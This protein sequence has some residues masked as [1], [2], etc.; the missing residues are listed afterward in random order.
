MTHKYAVVIEFLGAKLECENYNVA[1]KEL[2]ECKK[3]WEWQIDEIKN[4]S[5]KSEEEKYKEIEKLL[6]CYWEAKIERV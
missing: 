4:Y 2:T 1:R 5:T 6:R 3:N